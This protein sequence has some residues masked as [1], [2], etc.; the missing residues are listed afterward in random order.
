MTV[1]RPRL[2]A[3]MRRAYARTD[4]EAD[5]IVTRIGRRSAALDALLRRRGAR[6][7]AFVTAWNPYSRPMPRGWND[8][9]LAAL[10]QAAR[11]RVLAEGWGSG[12]G[13][14]ERHLLVAGDPRWIA[15]LARRFRQHAVVTVSPG[16]PAR[17]LPG[18][19]APRSAT[20]ADA[21]TRREE[22]V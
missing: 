11:G 1:H 6:H 8:R 3:A 7:A 20:D 16:H 5:G 2:S 9:M 19:V 14:A 21:R 13:W 4:Y 10:R 18:L 12:K 15:R 17:I 22:G